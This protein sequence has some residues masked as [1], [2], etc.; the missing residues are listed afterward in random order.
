MAK[1][2]AP[3]DVSWQQRGSAGSLGG[4]GGPSSHPTLFSHASTYPIAGP[5]LA[6]PSA[7][8]SISSSGS[9]HHSARIASASAR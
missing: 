6:H 8:R 4:S 7:K 9:A 2:A 5:L 3:P 1:A